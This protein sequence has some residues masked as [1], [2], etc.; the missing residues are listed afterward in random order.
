MLMSDHLDAIFFVEIFSSAAKFHRFCGWEKERMKE[1]A[2]EMDEGEGQTVNVR[3]KKRGRISTHYYASVRSGGG[4]VAIDDVEGS[5][6]L[7]A[8]WL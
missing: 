2:R 5:F 1:N 8:P 6:S 3:G 4:R 7:P